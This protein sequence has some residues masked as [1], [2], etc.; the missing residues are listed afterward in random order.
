[1][2][3]VYG[4][5]S[6]W[7]ACIFTGASVAMLHSLLSSWCV[8][9]RRQS[10]SAPFSEVDVETLSQPLRQ[11]VSEARALRTRRS[12][13][14]WLPMAGAIFSSALAY[15]PYETAFGLG[16]HAVLP[17]T[18]MNWPSLLLTMGAGFCLIPVVSVCW[19]RIACW[20]IKCDLQRRRKSL[21]D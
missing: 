18:M 20:R 4:S 7:F 8:E 15:R 11:L 12:I 1:M 13:P 19:V 9:K 6:L 3:P 5:I 10:S 21:I 14:L 2:I 17:V 16:D